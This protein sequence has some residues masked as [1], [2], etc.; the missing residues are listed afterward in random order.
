MDGSQIDP[1]SEGSRRHFLKAAMATGG[2][3]AV[4]STDSVLGP[5]A[6][7]ARPAGCPYRDTR[8]D[9]SESERAGHGHELGRRP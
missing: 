5:T 6:S 2:A 7:H 9:R 3:A 1:A 8:Q 4:A